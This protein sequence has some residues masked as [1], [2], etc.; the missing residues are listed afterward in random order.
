MSFKKVLRDLE[1][2]T[3]QQGP[4][5]FSF[6]SVSKG[7]VG[8][9][10]LRGGYMEATNAPTYMLDQLYKVASVSLCSNSVGQLAVSVMVNPPKLAEY[11]HD[12]EEKILSM[13]RRGQLAFDILNK[14]KHIKCQK[15]QGAMYAF[16]NLELPAKFVEKCT[17]EGK[18]ADNVY[19]MMLLEEQGICCVSGSGFL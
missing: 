8:E 15:I 12:A 5:L 9:C 10:G 14:N 7:F 6:H 11:Q 1:K 3:G 18:K 19:C 2:K 13:E 17:K 4:I 16:P